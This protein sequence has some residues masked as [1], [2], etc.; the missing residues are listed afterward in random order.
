MN[1]GAEC[2]KCN[3]IYESYEE[4]IRCYIDCSEVVDYEEKERE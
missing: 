2:L 1:K 3:N 4:A